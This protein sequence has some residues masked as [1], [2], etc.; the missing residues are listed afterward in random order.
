MNSIAHTIGAASISVKIRPVS[1][2]TPVDPHLAPDIAGLLSMME[3]AAFCGKSEDFS[4]CLNFF[5]EEIDTYLDDGRLGEEDEET[6]RI[7]QGLEEF[8]D[9]HLPKEV[10]QA[11]RRLDKKK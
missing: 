10:K 2:T 11:L 8:M 9:S 6:A 7:S 4:R 5:L 3:K 1:K